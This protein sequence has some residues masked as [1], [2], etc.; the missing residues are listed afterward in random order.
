MRLDGKEYRAGARVA[1]GGGYRDP[2]IFNINDI[3]QHVPE[4]CRTDTVFGV[5]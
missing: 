5:S 3:A 1:V 2:A 4:A